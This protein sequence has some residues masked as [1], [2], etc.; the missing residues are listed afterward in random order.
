MESA[1]QAKM[2]RQVFLLS[3]YWEGILDAGL[4]E[5]GITAKQLFML[6]LME[7]EFSEAPSIS[8][9]AARS[10]TS[11]QNVMQMARSLQ[12]RGFVVIEEDPVDRR[13]KKIRLTPHHRRFWEERGR[14]DE[15][16]LHQLFDPLDEAEQR[17]LKDILDQ[18]V[19]IMAERYHHR[20]AT[21]E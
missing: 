10:L 13:V 2:M 7:R 16:R 5:T 9:L 1:E 6:A 17:Q 14:M 11:H 19:P 21:Q 3:R 8:E 20:N 18:L 12:K 4:R 15:I